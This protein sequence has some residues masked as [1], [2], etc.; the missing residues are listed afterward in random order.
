MSNGTA[1]LAS[2]SWR[3]PS[4]P[5]AQRPSDQHGPPIACASSGQSA[6][7]PM[8]GGTGFERTRRRSRVEPPARSGRDTGPLWDDRR[9]R[10]AREN[11]GSLVARL[12]LETTGH[13]VR[14]AALHQVETTAVTTVIRHSN[15]AVED[16]R[17]APATARRLRPSSCQSPPGSHRA[18]RM[19]VMGWCRSKGVRCGSEW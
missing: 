4:W 14:S 17:S 2:R 11:A 16:E 19:A 3:F 10:L 1:A 6:Q 7:P 8:S 15:S 13:G 12:G 9:V 18:D 5:T